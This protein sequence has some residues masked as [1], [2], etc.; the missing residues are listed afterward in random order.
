MGKKVLILL[1]AA[2]L[3][4]AVLGGSAGGLEVFRIGGE[5]E[6]VPDQPGVNFHQLQWSDF[7]EKEGFDEEA[8]AAG[9]LRPFFLHPDENIALTSLARGG[10]LLVNT[11]QY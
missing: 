5:G 4:D 3:A 9:I 8:F 7:K 1:V 11:D 2:G 10:G 6:P